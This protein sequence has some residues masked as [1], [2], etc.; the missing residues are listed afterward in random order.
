MRV[1]NRVLATIALSAG[2]L[3]GALPAGAP[4]PAG[5]AVDCTVTATLINPCRPWLGA[6]VD[7]Y[8]GLGTSWRAQYEAHEAR[9][10]RRV[11]VVHGYKNVGNVKLT[12]DERHV[13]ARGSILYLNWKPADRWVDAG[14]GNATV[15]AQIDTLAAQIKALGS[16][17]VMLAVY[18]E[19]E[20]FTSIGSSACPGLKGSSGSP[21]QYR[22]MWANV[23][24]RFAAAG[25]ANVVWVMN[26]LGY[27]GWDCLFPELWPGNDRVDWVVWDP[28][29]GPGQRW[30]T[31][32]GYFYRAMEAKADAT[33]AYTSK[34]WGLA[35]YGS[36]RGAS[37]AEAYRMYD[38]A[39]AALD[40]GR[41]PRLKLY[42]VYDT[43]GGGNLDIRVG[44]SAAGVPDPAEQARYNAFAHHPAFSDP[45]TPPPDPDPTPTDH[46]AG[47]DKGV[48]KGL[49][50]F[51][52]TYS[53][54]LAPRWQTGAHSGA[55]SVQLTNTTTAARTAGVVV[56]PVPVAATVLGRTYTGA[57]WVKAS[58]VG[59]PITLELRERRPAT[60]A[61][62]TGG[63]RTITWTATHTTWQLLTGTHVAEEAGNRLT[64]SVFA[65][66]PAAQWFRADDFSLTSLP[67]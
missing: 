8:P 54:P 40:A 29:V 53:G 9:V 25:A 20:R 34:P 65:P 19:P 11:D 55:K 61:T 14:G 6:V 18:G 5:V 30:D 51:S 46:L 66:L 15:D 31:E 52:G 50:C 57:V 41:Y 62:P 13:A 3:V 27:S 35:E 49:S 28:Y 10:G 16:A 32:I 60:G 37:Q 63:T 67:A 59:I 24:A 22:A 21:A 39:R 44:Y 12:A 17:K 23:Q 7:H 33:H 45:V 2:L 38:D 4:A 64:Y 26:Y 48:E 58:K 56:T 42:E 36:W 47:C 43:I 1:Q